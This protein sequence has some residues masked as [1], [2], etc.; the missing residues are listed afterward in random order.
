M[1]QRRHSNLESSTSE[2]PQPLAKQ[3]KMAGQ[4]FATPT[5]S[6]LGRLTP[7][8]ILAMQR[9]HGNQY[10]QRMIEQR[11]APAPDNTLDSQQAHNVQFQLQSSMGSGMKLA[12]ASTSPPV[13]TL[14]RKANVGASFEHRFAPIA[15]DETI[16]SV[17]QPSARPN[18]SKD[19]K[20]AIINKQSGH[21][22]I[23][24]DRESLKKGFVF[25]HIVPYA[26]LID[27][28]QV[29][30]VGENINDAFNWLDANLPPSRQR[31]F[32]RPYEL[33]A[34]SPR[35][36]LIRNATLWLEEWQNDPKNFFIGSAAENSSLG[37]SFDD[38]SVA[39]TANFGA[40][41]FT[42]GDQ[43]QLVVSHLTQELKRNNSAVN[44]HGDQFIFDACQILGKNHQ[45][46]DVNDAIQ[47][48]LP[49]AVKSQYHTKQTYNQVI[50]KGSNPQNVLPKR[51]SEHVQ[52]TSLLSAQKPRKRSFLQRVQFGFEKGL[53]SIKKLV[54]RRPTNIIQREKVAKVGIMFDDI[55]AP[56]DQNK[57]VQDIYLPKTRPTITA[58]I[59]QQICARQN[60]HPGIADANTGKLNAGYVYRHIVPY[61]EVFRMLKTQLEGRTVKEAHDWFKAN[62][63][64]NSDGSNYQ[65]LPVTQ[66]EFED[67]ATQWLK[68]WQNDAA[69]FFIGTAAENSSIS[70]AFDDPQTA[71][72][73]TVANIGGINGL[74]NLNDFQNVSAASTGQPVD[75]HKLK[76]FT[77]HYQNLFIESLPKVN[78]QN[79]G[80]FA[81]EK[82]NNAKTLIL[83]EIGFLQGLKHNVRQW[84]R[85]G[86]DDQ[87]IENRAM[88]YLN[89]YYHMTQPSLAKW[90]ENMNMWIQKD[91]G[92]QTL[93]HFLLDHHENQGKIAEA[94]ELLKNNPVA[95]DDEPKKTGG[96]KQPS[97]RKKPGLGL[98]NQ[99]QQFFPQGLGAQPPINPNAIPQQVQLPQGQFG[100]QVQQPL[101]APQNNKKRNLDTLGA[102][103]EQQSKKQ[104][105]SA[106]EFINS[107]DQNQDN[108]DTIHNYLMQSAR[109][110]EYDEM[111][112]VCK[113][114]QQFVP[115]LDTRFRTIHMIA[116]AFY[117]YNKAN[118]E[119]NPMFNLIKYLFDMANIPK[120]DDH[121][122]NIAQ[123][124]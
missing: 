21:S 74:R 14:Q 114:I 5:L 81:R 11:R 85:L 4:Q 91:V 120:S 7:Q 78:E 69:N 15:D 96:F 39:D 16:K 76:K 68:D 54:Q 113:Q 89:Q 24:A 22:G 104:K 23:K 72:K 56:L 42:Q 53:K 40:G 29:G 121:A 3:G 26:A 71:D 79:V 98:P 48:V 119:P 32:P 50:S 13:A 9:T 2:A 66:D 25:R 109:S 64:A 35:A 38:P 116:Q 87:T 101:Q 49:D 122:K 103:S 108:S 82:I 67:M 107:L 52:R 60:G 61:A 97:R 59:K 100:G 94:A 70:D 73:G 123:Q 58:G 63:L 111:K 99:G 77:D 17:H 27:M 88:A 118:I 95:V 28:L 12:T 6:R 33:S 90:Q 83:S 46:N 75:G 10:V 80:G 20:R 45:P 37:D 106:T 34:Q 112:I 30:L 124:K 55:N 117:H 41:V 57:I 92:G 47:V 19:T 1:K 65:K 8:A 105:R 93:N 86:F 36:M 31:N 51:K 84:M 110:G 62:L 18:I 43:K 115:N 102:E 44:S